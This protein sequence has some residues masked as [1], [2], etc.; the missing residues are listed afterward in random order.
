MS[1]TTKK[2]FI[3]DASIYFFRAYFAVSYEHKSKSSHDVAA[4]LSYARWLFSLIEHNSPQ[5]IV[6]CFDESLGSGFRHRIDSDYKANRALPDDALAYQLLASKK[7]TEL[8][9]V[10]CYASSEFEA[11]DLIAS[12]YSNSINRGLEPIVVSADKDLSQLLSDSQGL[13]WDYPKKTAMNKTDLSKLRGFPIDRMP[14]YLALVGD[15]S[16][17]IQGVPGVGDK[18]ASAL[19]ANYCDWADVLANLDELQGLP[20]RS[21]KKLKALFIEYTP[22]IEKNLR[23]T[24]LRHDALDQDNIHLR[25]GVGDAAALKYL[26]LEFNAPKSLINT[27]TKVNYENNCR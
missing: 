2:V 1:I 7:L 14:L 12:V 16:D 25:K 11:D 27:L 4:T 6:V 15:A 9:G 23:L 13:Y 10:T 18:T 22:T 8:A 3:I 26:L 17:N 21:A 20:I 19:L 5:F 24:Q